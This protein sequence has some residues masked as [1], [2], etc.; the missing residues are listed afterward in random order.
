MKRACCTSWLCAGCTPNARKALPVTYKGVCV[1]CG[2]RIDLLVESAVIVELKAAGRIEP[3][4]ESQLLSYLKI[5]RCRIG[6][7]INF[8]VKQ[9][10]KGL[11]RLVNELLG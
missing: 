6:R 1:D 8:N 5:S 4:H 10:A 2:Y 9:L 3:I 11:R 7:L